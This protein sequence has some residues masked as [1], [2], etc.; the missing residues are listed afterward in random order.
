VL[1]LD[2]A[3]KAMDLLMA[4]LPRLRQRSLTRWMH[5]IERRPDA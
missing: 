3:D 4:S 5:I 1:P 2:S